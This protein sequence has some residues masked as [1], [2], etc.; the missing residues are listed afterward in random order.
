LKKIKLLNILLLLLLSFSISHAFIIE[1]EHH[2][3]VNEYIDEFSHSLHDDADKP[4]DL[5]C[6]FHI[7]YILTDAFCI[8]TNSQIT[9]QPFSKS[10]LYIYHLLYNFLKPPIT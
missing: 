2:S 5:H 10:K 3:S 9:L 8:Q 6:E 4:C 1:D 7:S